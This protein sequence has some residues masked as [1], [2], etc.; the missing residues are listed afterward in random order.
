MRKHF[1]EETII[2]GN[3]YLNKQLSEE[4]YTGYIYLRKQLSQEA[5]ILGDMYLSKNVSEETFI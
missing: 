1:S 2:R 5:V 4:N 3:S